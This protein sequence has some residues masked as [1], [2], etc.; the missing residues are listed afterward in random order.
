VTL[1]FDAKPVFAGHQT[2]HPRFGWIK[3]A[4]DSADN[5]PLIFNREDATVVLGVG[6]NMV[7]AIRFWG[8]AFKVITAVQNPDSKRST[9]FVPTNIGK[10]IFDS[11]GLDTFAEN[12]ATLW[13]L[14]WF[15]NSKPSLLPVWRCFINEFQVVEFTT[16]ELEVFCEEQI[17]GTP[18]KK[19]VKASISKDVD[20]IIRMYSS[21][22]ARGRQTIDDLMDS[23][24]RQLGLL[25]GSPAGADSYRFVI[26]EKPF[27]SDLIIAYCCIDFIA[28]NDPN[29]KTVT[30]TRLASDGG[31]PGRLLKISESK[32]LEA[33]ESS[34][35]QVSSITIA[36]PA[37][38]SQLVLSKAPQ[39]VAEEILS[40]IYKVSSKKKGLNIPV[41]GFDAR[42]PYSQRTD[43]KK[44][45]AS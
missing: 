13:L 33:L 29:S 12:P 24:F 44:K 2:F 43:G 15:A 1:Q 28:S 36:S 5:D 4:F 39:V 18:W 14:H 7:E 40:K 17:S 9:R 41:V 32:I 22:D 10:A 30:T 6:K 23:P 34:C 8:T 19:P 31:G 27:L 21:R 26:G 45:L 20:C 35:D 16:N 11:E 38:A 42:E 37:G 25:S 3:K